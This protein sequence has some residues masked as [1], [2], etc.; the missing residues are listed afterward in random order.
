MRFK[1]G[2]TQTDVFSLLAH[3]EVAPK[4]ASGL[5]R[6]AVIDWDSF[7]PTLL[8]HLDYSDKGKGGR[9]PWCPVLMLKV[10][11]LQ[12]FHG[13]SD[14]QTEFQLHDRLSFQRFV[15]LRLGDDVPDHSTIWLFK[16]TLGA[17][18]MAAVFA[19]FDA[20]LRAQGL[21]ASAGQI[22][23]A[24]FV[25]APKQRNTRAENAQIK[26]GERPASFDE[27]PPR[28]CQK[29]TDARWTVK[30]GRSYYGYKN[31]VKI[32]AA[33]KLIET[34]VTTPAS[35]HDSQTVAALLRESDR[36]KI[37]L[38]DSAF[39]GEP[40]AQLL[41]RY[42]LI[43]DICEKGTKTKPLTRAQKCENRK[44]NR[45]RARVEH[46]FG[47]IAQFGGDHFRRIG[48]ARCEFEN[49]LTNLTYN[50]DRYAYLRAP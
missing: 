19:D 48:Q 25:E 43:A 31:H 17:A 45:W 4:R 34:S 6:L 12:R 3:A 27:N 24:S 40:I 26:R 9:P 46:V 23:D 18:G 22:V 41:A 16:E 38:G 13:L 15:G 30:G 42:G 10:L 35:V 29:D 39:T 44:R 1:T 32:D 20:Q 33:S 7:R 50:L 2:S 8:A 37:F 49:L 28:A 47:R 5:E 14:E 11:I 21:L 36:G